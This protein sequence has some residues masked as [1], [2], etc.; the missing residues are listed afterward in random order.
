MGVIVQQNYTAFITRYPEFS[1]SGTQPVSN[2]LYSEY[3]CEAEL[4]QA[5]NGAGPIKSQTQALLL[6]NMMV[7]HI[8]SL[9]TAAF[10][11]AVAPNIVGRI[12][13]AT[14]GSVTVGT[15]NQYPPGTPQWYQQ[16]KYGAAWWAA[17]AQFRTMRYRPGPVMGVPAQQGGFFGRFGRGCGGSW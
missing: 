11:G 16:T 15:D 7:A 8:A 4:Y 17:T 5:N 12:A 2:P 6:M 10:N 3:W 9:N 1:S 13:N 14:E